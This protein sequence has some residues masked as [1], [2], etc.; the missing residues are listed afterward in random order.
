MRLREFNKAVEI[1]SK[2]VYSWNSLAL[3]YKLSGEFD[4]ALECLDKAI[5]IDSKDI[6]NY[7]SKAI[8]LFQRG[9]LEDAKFVI[10]Q[11]LQSTP[12]NHLLLGNLGEIQMREEDFRGARRTFKKIAQTYPDKSMDIIVLVI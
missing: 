1:D 11:A 9:Q 5:F 10:E 6:Y 2:D 4:M 12:E 3:A 7:N 8:I